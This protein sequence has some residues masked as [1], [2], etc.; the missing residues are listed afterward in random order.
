[1]WHKIQEFVRNFNKPKYLLKIFLIVVIYF[2]S[3]KF[4]LTLSGGIEQVSLVWPATGIAISSLLILGISYWPGILIGAFLANITSNETFSMAMGI[5]IGNT[6][7]AVSATWL[8]SI[9]GFRKDFGRVRDAVFFI[10]FAALLA[11]AISATI[12]VISLITGGVGSW[13]DFWLIWREWWIGDMIGALI[14]APFILIRSDLQKL[15]KFDL[16][17]FLTSLGLTCAFVF[18]CLIVS[19]PLITVSLVR[20]PL[21][22]LLLPTIILSSF[23]LKQHGSTWKMLI[24]SSFSVLSI[25]M[26]WGEAE[27]LFVQIFLGTL[28]MFFLIFSALVAEH[29]ESL[30]E[31]KYS[32]RKFKSLIEHSFNGVVLVDMTGK[33]IYASPSTEKVLGWNA[34]EI[35]GKSGF[36]LIYPEDVHILKDKLKELLTESGRVVQTEYRSLHKDGKV[37]FMEASGTNLLQDPAVNAI[38]VNFRDITDRKKLDEAKSEFVSFTAHELRGPLSTT[39]WYLEVLLALKELQKG[40]IQDYL[41]AVYSAN[42]RMNDTVN[43]L[44][45][46]N[47]ME[48]GRLTNKPEPIDITAIVKQSLIT[49]DEEIKSKKLHIKENLPTKN[50]PYILLDPNLAGI[51]IN[52]LISNAVKYTPKSGSVEVNSEVKKGILSFVVSD[53]GLGIPKSQESR[54]FTKSFRADNVKE[55]VPQG[56]GLGLYLTKSVIDQMGGKIYFESNLN[57]GTV[58]TVKIPVQAE[59]EKRK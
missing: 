20:F 19:T 33:V 36:D 43:L 52:N 35:T 11:T 18:I 48:M 29:N 5:A 10:I 7:E 12:G 16:R 13:K 8:L 30:L 37:H 49:F 51:V 26:G 41:W 58:F 27:L 54:I 50:Q 59:N 39:R 38:V 22:Y 2:F 46:I 1:M 25:F 57:K 42:L 21:Q 28:A 34:E 55:Q 24:L 3:A 44:L 31:V 14:V 17:T 45:N 23:L 56:T 6:L 9:I 53:T 4:G 15:L 32:E 47:R 40:K